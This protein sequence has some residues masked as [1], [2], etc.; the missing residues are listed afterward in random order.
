MTKKGRIRRRKRSDRKK[1]LEGNRGRGR[2]K[3]LQGRSNGKRDM[4]RVLS[5]DVISTSYLV[6][7]LNAEIRL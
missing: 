6:N 3:G 7:D 5:A 2:E 1:R 4:A